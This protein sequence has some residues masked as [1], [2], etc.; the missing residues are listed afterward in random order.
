[1]QVIMD[2]LLNS[3][4]PYLDSQQWGR[5]WLTVA[6]FKYGWQALYMDEEGYAMRGFHTYAPTLLKAVEDL[7]KEIELLRLLEAPAVEGEAL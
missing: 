3:L 7:K 2:N 6:T 4:P 1:M 5:C